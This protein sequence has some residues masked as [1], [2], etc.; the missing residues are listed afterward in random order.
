MLTWHIT[1]GGPEGTLFELGWNAGFARFR[2][3]DR[4]IAEDTGDLKHGDWLMDGKWLAFHRRRERTEDERLLVAAFGIA[5]GERY[6]LWEWEPRRPK[7]IDD[8]TPT[9]KV[10]D[11]KRRYDEFMTRA[12]ARRSAP[13][14]EFNT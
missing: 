6:W 8:R 2:P 14:E 3:L 5:F 1:R 13:A 12:V 7:V 9:E 11:I 10:A 4:D